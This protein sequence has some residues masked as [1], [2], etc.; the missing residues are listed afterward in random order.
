MLNLANGCRG[1]IYYGNN[2]KRQ[3]TK[4]E[5]SLIGELTKYIS[6]FIDK[7]Y[8]VD[9][10]NEGLRLYNL[11]LAQFKVR[12]WQYDL[13]TYRLYKIDSSK[14]I[15]KDGCIENFPESFIDAGAVEAESIDAF[16]KLHEDLKNGIESSGVYAIMY[17]DGKF[18]WG[19]ITYKLLKNKDG[20][21]YRALGICEDTG[22]CSK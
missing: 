7:A 10:L 14:T 1:A 4:C 6:A 3:W 8:S 5:L 2:A 21:P 18:H 20:A 12:L 19:R 15:W 17:S 22:L 13:I 16:R 11:A 9:M